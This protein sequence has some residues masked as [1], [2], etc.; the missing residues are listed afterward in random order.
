MGHRVEKGFALFCCL[1]ITSCGCNL[2]SSRDALLV[3][4]KVELPFSGA[5]HGSENPNNLNSP[6]L[7]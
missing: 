7:L 4:A 6:F 2:Q 1:S 3:R 5:I